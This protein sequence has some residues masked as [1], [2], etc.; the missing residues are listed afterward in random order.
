MIQFS[1]DLLIRFFI[2][3]LLLLCSKAGTYASEQLR[4]TYGNLEECFSSIVNMACGL[5]QAHG[6]LVVN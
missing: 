5:P 3:L 4:M 1:E 2:A 6:R